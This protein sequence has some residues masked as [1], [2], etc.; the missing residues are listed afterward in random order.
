MAFDG[1]C[2]KRIVYEYNELFK[3]ARISKGVA[4]TFSRI[5]LFLAQE[6]LVHSFHPVVCN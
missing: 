4:L 5:S 6:K 1:F 2:I 3:D